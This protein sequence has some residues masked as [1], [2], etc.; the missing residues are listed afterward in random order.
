MSKAAFAFI[1]CRKNVPNN[2]CGPLLYTEPINHKLLYN[3][4]HIFVPTSP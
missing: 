2:G 1:K 3:L 4:L